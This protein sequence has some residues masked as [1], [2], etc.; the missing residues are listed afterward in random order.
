[1]PEIT[2]LPAGEHEAS[3]AYEPPW[4]EGVDTSHGPAE[5]CAMLALL[6]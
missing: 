4:A 1:M 5:T 2:D 6:P 3:D